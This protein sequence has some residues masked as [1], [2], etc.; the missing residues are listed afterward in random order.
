MGA[1]G[2]VGMF[3]NK[4][5]FYRLQMV[6]FECPRVTNT[7]VSSNFEEFPIPIFWPCCF[8]PSSL[9]RG[10]KKWELPG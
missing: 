6:Q 2:I 3:L 1:G 4:I 5:S 10:N 8:L 9:C 7:L